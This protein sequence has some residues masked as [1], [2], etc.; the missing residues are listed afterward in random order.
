[1][2]SLVVSA[3]L[4]VTGAF[5]LLSNGVQSASAGTLYNGWNYSIDAF[6]DGSPDSALSSIYDIKGIAIKKDGGKV[7]VAISGNTLL[8]GME[9]DKAG[10][11]IGWGD[12]FF[13]FTGKSFADANKNGQ[14]FGVHFA[15]ANDSGVDALGLYSGVKALDKVTYKDANGKNQT[16]TVTA[17]NNGYANLNS[18]YNNSGGKWYKEGTQGDLQDKAD[19]DAYYGNG[20]QILPVIGTGT[21]IGDINLLSAT[22]LT[23]QG[24]NFGHFNANPVQKTQT[25]QKVTTILNNPQI[26]GFMFDESLLPSSNYIANIFLECGNDGVAIKVPEPS[27]MAGLAVLG[28]SAGLG[29]RKRR[30]GVVA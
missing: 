16:T 7:Y 21:K 9:K 5:Y 22:E 26:F 4:S 19:T 8:G 23:A 14:L 17:L 2:R 18:Y 12:L 3:L 15:D 30:R 10:G 6:G 24:I 25:K 1:M 28:L 29:L 13:N 27:A 20:N 11:T